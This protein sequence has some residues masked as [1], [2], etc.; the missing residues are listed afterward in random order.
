MIMA[1]EKCYRQKKAQGAK[2][3]RRRGHPPVLEEARA[4]CRQGPR[5]QCEQHCP[6]QQAEEA[7]EEKPSQRKHYQ[8]RQGGDCPGDGVA[9]A[10]AGVRGRWEARKA[11]W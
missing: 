7:E 5:G 3:A 9:G 2:W 1:C 11:R 4:S 6:E 8:Q 10:K